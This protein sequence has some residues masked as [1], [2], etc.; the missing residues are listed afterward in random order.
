M[1]QRAGRLVTPLIDQ[2]AHHREDCEAIE[3]SRLD[4]KQRVI[5][6]P[7]WLHR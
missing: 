3:A 6:T 1:I 5:R 4:W 7:Y 2:A